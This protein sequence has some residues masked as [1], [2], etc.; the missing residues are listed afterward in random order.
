MPKLNFNSTRLIRHFSNNY[1]QFVSKIVL[2]SFCKSLASKPLCI[3]GS[4][5]SKTILRRSTLTYDYDYTLP[6][7]LLEQIAE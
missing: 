4:V 3:L 2:M 5:I 1:E 6:N 7:E